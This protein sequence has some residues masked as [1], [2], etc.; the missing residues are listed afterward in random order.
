MSSRDSKGAERRNSGF[1]GNFSAC[2]VHAWHK[3]ASALT[4]KGFAAHSASGQS[5]ANSRRQ[6]KNLTMLHIER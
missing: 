5:P 1:C 4:G 2:E 3:T 6:I